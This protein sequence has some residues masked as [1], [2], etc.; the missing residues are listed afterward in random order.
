MGP[1]SNME[2]NESMVCEPEEEVGEDESLMADGE[3]VCEEDGGE[4]VSGGFT[5]MPEPTSSVSNF[6]GPSLSS[7]NLST[8]DITSSEDS[9][10][11]EI[12]RHLSVPIP[13]IANTGS[14]PAAP[15]ESPAPSP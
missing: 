12:A 3:E 7:P 15:N 8:S 4:A 11:S 2:Q 1:T 10:Y 6:S 9:Y 5:P 13:Q 14:G